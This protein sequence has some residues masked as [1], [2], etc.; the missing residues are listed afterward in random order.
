MSACSRPKARVRSTRAAAGSVVAALL[1]LAL[2]SCKELPEIPEGECGNL[3]LEGAED[4]D[5]F[6]IDGFECRPKGAI[7]A[8][9]FDCSRQPN[10]ERGSCPNDF[11]CGADEV[12]RRATGRFDPLPASV[13]GN[14]ESLQ[15]GDFDGD[16]R[17]DIVGLR[18]QTLFGQTQVSIFY[19]D[20][21]GALANRW[22]VTES[23][24][25]PH[26][27]NGAGGDQRADLLGS[28]AALAVLLGE[29]DRTLSPDVRPS[30]HIPDSEVLVVPVAA[31]P[32]M[33]NSP[34][35]V[36]VERDGK[37]ELHKP[38]DA[39]HLLA[40]L[41][42]LPGQLAN[43]AGGP[44]TGWLFENEDHPCWNVVLAQLD[45]SDVSSFQICYRDPNDGTIRFREQA[46]ET[47]LS[48]PGGALI[49][50][51][52]LIADVDCNGHNDLLVASATA[53]FVAFGDGTEL[54]PF[55]P[56]AV[57]YYDPR[58]ANPEERPPLLVSP[59]AA[60]DFTGDGCADLV[61]PLGVLVSERLPDS[62][63]IG[64]KLAQYAAEPWAEARI[65][66]L[67]GDSLPD[68]VMTLKER[69]DLDVFVGTNSDRPNHLRIQTSY[70][71]SDLATGDFDGD[72][73]EDVGFFQ[74]GGGST[75]DDEFMVSFGGSFASLGAPVS[76]GHVVDAVDLTT[77][78]DNP[79]DMT[80]DLVVM[81]R[82]V[83]DRGEAGAALSLL[84]GN[85]NR[86]FVS[87]IQLTSSNIEGE[88]LQGECIN[89]TTGRFHGR[90][91]L[92]GLALASV[93][94][95]NELAP[96]ALWLLPNLA[97]TGS[98]PRVIGWA[99]DELL[100]PLIE[101]A[102]GSVAI[103]ASLRAGDVEG[104]GV[105]ELIA[106]SP[107]KDQKCVVEVAK[108]HPES[109]SSSLDSVLVL[110]HACV[111]IPPIRMV[112]LDLDGLSDLVLQTGDAEKIGPIL[113]LWNEAGRGL[114]ARDVAMVVSETEAPRA[115]DVYSGNSGSPPRLAYV[116]EKS[117]YV[118]ETRR[119]SRSFKNL[120]RAATLDGAT[121]VTAGDVDGDGLID[122]AVADS[123]KVRILKAGLSSR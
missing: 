121:G 41:V 29:P 92:D 113:V 47:R 59:I 75:G 94:P 40:K 103:G 49:E 100:Q 72:R 67:T 91:Q 52:P 62:S 86:N 22:N 56:Y 45:S 123:G 108:I 118:V 37:F 106:A 74:R 14:F 12:C 5:T 4:C 109:T 25:N 50:S 82:L 76:A 84:E 107:T 42:D 87:P 57:R 119:G 71:A 23:L 99:F 26:V 35:V 20:A 90:T 83:N 46:L 122:L 17:A 13:P 115:F 112:D 38:A 111:P 7:G 60:G 117:A 18:Q 27:F 8:C 93:V 81:H 85:P 114:D 95:E 6:V 98:T 101:N 16:G 21:F 54:L 9:H 34:L 39:T 97:F 96:F 28:G 48:L 66:D 89:L 65:A 24:F 63:G 3:V 64:Y 55:A 2:S 110:D 43:L 104:D 53:L 70:P 61:D 1:V 69:P 32:V 19:F 11:G 79:A 58:E 44:T 80:S 78:A 15:S 31:E 68:V 105:D 33:G 102:D 73:S 77:L 88:L 120:G 10:G 36:L 116:T 30:Y 51:Q